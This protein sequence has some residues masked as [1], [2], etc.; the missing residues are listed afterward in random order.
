MMQR[1]KVVQTRLSPDEKKALL[2][3]SRH[4]R[5]KPS[6]LVRELIRQEAVR[7]GLWPPQT[8]RAG[9]NGRHDGE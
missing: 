3:V 2:A 7:L 4:V 1:I 9:A 8:S 6:E 5:R